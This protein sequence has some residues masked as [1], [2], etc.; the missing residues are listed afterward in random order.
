MDLP[1]LLQLG[2]NIPLSIKNIRRT[3]GG[4]WLLRYVCHLRPFNRLNYQMITKSLSFAIV[5]VKMGLNVLRVKMFASDKWLN[6]LIIFG[7]LLHQYEVAGGLLIIFVLLQTLPYFIFVYADFFTLA[8][9]LILDSQFIPPINSI[10]RNRR[11]S[12]EPLMFSDLFK[13]NALIRLFY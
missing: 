4:Q 11:H 5:M 2:G 1:L 9:E 8:D 12:I 10:S 3:L 6:F 13:W 7:Q